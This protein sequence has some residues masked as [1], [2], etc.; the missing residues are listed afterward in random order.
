MEEQLHPE[1]ITGR[2]IVITGQQPWDVNIGSNCKNIAEEFSKHNRVLYV[3]T[4]LDR[5]TSWR[6]R[7]QPEII[8]RKEI[9]RG[10]K[11][12]VEQI[13]ANLWVLTPDCK[14]ESINWIGIQKL[15]E[16][17]NKINNK[18]FATT[19][20]AAIKELGFSNIILFNDNDMFR[21]YHLKELLKPCVSIYYSRDYMLAVDYWKKHGKKME[22]ELIA[23]SDICVANSTYLA[24]YCRQYNPASFYVGQGCELELFTRDIGAARPA[25]MLNMRG[26]IIGYVGALQSIRL[27]IDIIRH[28]AVNR[29][30]W[31]IVLVGP[32]DTQFLN[33]D[34]HTIPNVYFLGSKPVEEIPVYVNAFDVC[35]NPQ[36]VN[37]VTIGNYPRKIDEYLAMGK[38]VVATQ[39]DAMSV[40]SEHCYLAGS[41]EAYVTLISKAL[42]EDSVE[43]RKARMEFAA[44]HTWKN[45]VKD[46]YSAIN[47]TFE[48][49]ATLPEHLIILGMP[50]Y[51][52]DLESTSYMLAKEL[53][54]HF[55][56]YY[57][58]NPFTYRDYVQ[59]HN[60]PQLQKRKEFFKSSSNGVIDTTVANLKVVI[61]PLIPSIHFLP[62]GWLYRRLLRIS[63]HIIRKRIKKTLTGEGTDRF[64][65]LNSFNFHYPRVM[66]KADPA[67]TIYHSLDPMIMD[68]DKKHG[69]ISEPIVVKESDLV[70]CSAKALAEQ[71]RRVN[72]NTYFLPNAADVTHARKALEPGLEI[73]ASIRSVPH[74]VIGYFGNIER[75]IDY[76]LVE[77]VAQL[78][79]SY[80]FVFAGPY[81]DAYIPASFKSLPNVFLT[82]KV[83]YADMPAVIKGFDV[84]IIPFQSDEVSSSI[85][86]LKLFEYLGAGKPVVATHFNPNLKQFTGERVQYQNEPGA[87]AQALEAACAE[88]N[89]NVQERVQLASENTWVHRARQLMELMQQTLKQQQNNNG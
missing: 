74:P 25:D 56:V 63:E 15:F 40:F 32:E 33:S 22:P 14:L 76:K 46:I 71:F 50:R 84:A 12:A 36:L 16:R 62:E 70:V 24:N 19:I 9:I 20:Q 26:P 27:S 1:M 21:S 39:T 78:L 31:N 42:E 80:H 49:R 10:N 6:N 55:K 86:P 4:P 3:N 65:Y 67:L 53:A 82:G 8:K 7:H 52:D 23:K 87:F 75:R 69:L 35:I 66:D 47:Q 79:P 83:P 64:I 34:L 59:S 48:K 11:D 38:P 54:A 51:D 45:S 73:H 58:D 30:D 68:F 28:L 44:G 72:P 37:Q 13:H 57:V 89:S 5:I 85:F 18:R 77:T 61:T 2:D 41:K 81:N 43:K 17:L 29:P 60:T 88:R